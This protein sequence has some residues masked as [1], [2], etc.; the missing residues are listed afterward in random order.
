LE[1]GD[2]T[3]LLGEV[4]T[5]ELSL[6]EGGGVP[7]DSISAVS[8]ELP[9]APLLGQILAPRLLQ[10]VDKNFPELGCPD[11]CPERPCGKNVAKKKV[12]LIMG[13]TCKI[14]GPI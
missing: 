13:A 11:L 1:T 6:V 12:P 3:N 10:L 5:T 4:G 7:K 2:L 8:P 14:L 9:R